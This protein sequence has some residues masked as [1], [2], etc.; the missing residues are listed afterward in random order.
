MQLVKDYRNKVG[1]RT[2]GIKLYGELKDD[3]NSHNIKI[4][5]DKFYRFL[6]DNSLL[7]PKLKN[8]HTTT[9]SKHQFKK[10]KNILKNQVPTRPEQLWVSDITYIKTDNWHNYLALVTDAFS[11]QIMGYKLA[12]HIKITLY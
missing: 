11:K 7:V 12:C 10:Y 2:G 3:F 9:N 4:G 6:R 5:R 1:Q 8:Y